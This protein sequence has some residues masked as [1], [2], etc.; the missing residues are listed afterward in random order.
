[1]GRLEDCF[2]VMTHIMAY[3]FMEGRA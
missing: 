1:M 3:A 2:F